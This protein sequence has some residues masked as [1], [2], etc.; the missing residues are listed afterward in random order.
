MSP[1]HRWVDVQII[2]GTRVTR[3][4]IQ[5]EDRWRGADAATVLHTI[6]DELGHVPADAQIDALLR[7]D[8]ERR[9]EWLPTVLALA[10][11]AVLGALIG[12]ALVALL[13]VTWLPLAAPL[14]L[15][16]WGA[17]VAL[18]VGLPARRVR[19]RRR[20]T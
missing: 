14:A 2:D 10:L 7:G 12:V 6:A 8:A 9:R 13:P 5:G 1:H 4:R 19:S 20:R 15:A 18:D 17:L 3:A 16:A 11:V